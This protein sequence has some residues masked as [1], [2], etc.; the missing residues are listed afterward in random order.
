MW[1]IT[2]RRSQLQVVRLMPTA[3][4]TRAS[5]CLI[6][7]DELVLVGMAQTAFELFYLPFDES[8]PSRTSLLLLNVLASLKTQTR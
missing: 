8:R 2:S 5:F 6:A 7:L 1:L 3:Q 4:R